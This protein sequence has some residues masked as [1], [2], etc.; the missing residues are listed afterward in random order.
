M[1]KIHLIE[2]LDNFVAK[3]NAFRAAHATDYREEY[4]GAA[5]DDQEAAFEELSEEFDGMLRDEPE[6]LLALLR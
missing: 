3:R 2:L 1:D 4:C 5:Y 6:A